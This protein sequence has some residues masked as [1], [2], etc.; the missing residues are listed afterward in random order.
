MNKAKNIKSALLQSGIEEIS[1]YGI[2][3]FSL[4]RVATRCG[5]SCAAPYKHFESKEQFLQE[6]FREIT[7]SWHQRQQEVLSMGL[8][9]AEQL[10]GLVEEYITFMAD[11][12]GYANLIVMNYP[13]LGD[14]MLKMKRELTECLRDTLRKICDVHG[15]SDEVYYQKLFA[16]RS[17]IYGAVVM[18]TADGEDSYSKAEVIRLM[19][20]VLKNE[21]DMS[22][23]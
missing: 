1:K 5:V 20:K 19:G 3:E 13:T 21:F 12:P 8:A 16:L 22:A 4:R 11:N 7:A 18:M 6:I 15:L 2:R 17:N 23:T 10:Y 9:P 14:A